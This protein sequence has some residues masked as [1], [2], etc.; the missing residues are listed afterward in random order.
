MQ[1]DELGSYNLLPPIL[2]MCLLFAVMLTV[3]PAPTG[4]V[5]LLISL[6]YVLL[7]IV[8]ITDTDRIIVANRRYTGVF[9]IF[10]VVVFLRTALEP[11]TSDVTRLGALLVFTISNIFIL[12]KVVSFHEFIT[13]SSISAMIVV[14][15]GYFPFLGLPVEIGF[16]EL[17]TWRR[18][19]INS[20]I[21]VVT[22]IFIKPNHLGFISLLGIFTSAVS[23]GR[24]K[25]NIY[26]I[27]LV[28]NFMGF[29]MT[30]YRA[31]WFGLMAAIGLYIVY[32]KIGRTAGVFATVGGLT[33]CVL[34]VM[35]LL[36]LIPIPIP[37]ILSTPRGELWLTNIEFLK[38]KWIF[39]Y[40]FSGV[41]INPHNSYIRMFVAF[42]VVGGLLYLYL[43][44]ET[45]ISSARQVTSNSK[46]IL[47][48][49]LVSFAIIQIFNQLTFIGISMRSTIIAIA[50][51]Y[52]ITLDEVI[53]PTTD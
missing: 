47:S 10:L 17:T 20:K 52:Y 2:L 9:F 27:P 41:P 7:S 8:F 34:G 50:M 35:V 15:V 46:L 43:V 11:T 3:T 53:S 6:I 42:G 45:A 48:I 19:I 13:V 28:V 29:A 39:G 23:W 24:R 12:P 5:Y 22:S 14:L 18:S 1:P 21:P 16:F 38:Q 25:D 40:N 51:G 44:L 30:D 32:S 49:L 37:E 4:P 33:A 26:S 36:D 31:G